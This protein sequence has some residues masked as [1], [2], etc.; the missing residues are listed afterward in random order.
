MSGKVGLHL[1]YRWVALHTSFSDPL[2]VDEPDRTPAHQ[3][4]SPF[5]ACTP[6]ADSAFK[7]ANYPAFLILRC[8]E[9]LPGWCM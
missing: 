9:L 7:K 6:E 1:V 8:V 3:L 4:P 5:L 2:L